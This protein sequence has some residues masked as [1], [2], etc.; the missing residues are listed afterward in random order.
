MFRLIDPVLLTLERLNQHRIL[1]IWV[2]VGLS[3]ATTLTLSLALYVDAVYSDLLASRLGDPPFAFRFRYLGAWNGNITPGDAERASVF[4]QNRFVDQIGLPVARQVAFVRVGTWSVRSDQ[5][6][7]GSLSIGAVE[8]ANDQMFITAGQWPPVPPEAGEPIPVLAPEAMF[9]DM[10]LQPGDILTESSPGSGPLNLR[11][12]ALWRPVDPHDPTW[13]FAPKFFNEILLVSPEGFSEIMLRSERPVD[14]VAWYLVFDGSNVRTTDVGPLLEHISRTQRELDSILPGIRQ[15]LSPSAGL[16]SFSREVDRLTQQLFIIVAPVGGL[17]LYFVS[18]VAGLLVQRQRPE[19]VTLRSRGMSRRALLV[20][21]VLMWLALVGAALGI[22]LAA[23]PP[24]VSLVGQ[25]SSFLRFDGVS[26]VSRVVLTP[27]A[28]TLSAVTG[29]VTASTGLFLAW[30]STRRNIHLFQPQTACAGSAWWQRA[31]L[32][33]LLLAV[34]GYLLY[35]LRQQNGFAADTET[36]FSDPLMFVGPTLFALS[37]ALLF[38]RLW[39]R[40]LTLIAWLVSLTSSIALLMAL[41][42]LTRSGGRYRGAVLMMAFTLSLTGFTA[43]MASTLDRSLIDTVDYR[44]GADMVIVTAVDAETER[45]QSED[46]EQ[47]T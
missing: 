2:L 36:P 4:I 15:D 6:S 19:D 12:A 5:L 42:E 11:V 26:S 1:V 32:D 40:V 20:V 45:E 24:V 16:R 30:R 27:Q 14:E 34:A 10:G 43:S 46:S 23:G 47:T 33:M 44:I 37:L 25:T 29:F 18:L 3:V 21:H 31:Y 8:S 7:L 9:Y 13:I 17:V 28:L 22:A 35:T 39:P 41:R 38:I